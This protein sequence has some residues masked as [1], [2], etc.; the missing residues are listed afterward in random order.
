MQLRD[1]NSQIINT[2]EFTTND[3]GS[4]S[5]EYIL[6][7]NGLTGAFSLQVISSQVSIS[8]YSS[9]SVE[10]YKRPK[11]ETSFEPITETYK[12][13]DSLTVNGKATAYA[14][15]NI[16]DAKVAYRVKRVVY[17]PRWYYWSRPYFN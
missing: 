16:T 17:Y 9:F 15:S 10:E 13:N 2:Q 8:G 4:F 5:G 7:N 3:Y 11:F 6:P 12:V 1:V 14:G